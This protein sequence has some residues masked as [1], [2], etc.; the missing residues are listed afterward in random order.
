MQSSNVNLLSNVLGTPDFFWT[1][2]DSLGALYERACEYM[3][4]STRVDVLNAR[5]QILQV[6]AHPAPALPSWLLVQT[7]RWPATTH[8]ALL[9]A[10]QSSV[11]ASGR[12]KQA[13][14]RILRAEGVSSKPSNFLT[15]KPSV[16]V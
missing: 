11:H 3:E 2:P 1:A 10:C 6:K 16:A 7:A 12:G 9:M 8:H 5:F 13:L 14:E 15:L 4:L